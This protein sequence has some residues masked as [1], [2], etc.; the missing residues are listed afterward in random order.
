MQ[1]QHLRLLWTRLPGREGDH[2]F[3]SD[4]QHHFVQAVL[5]ATRWVGLKLPKTFLWAPLSQK[6]HRME[7]T[8]EPTEEQKQR[9]RSR[10]K[11][12][13]RHLSPA[14]YSTDTASRLL[15]HLHL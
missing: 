9:N 2:T 1:G 14:F 15:Y 6:R 5:T 4:P 12:G 13:D 7:G 8:E 10:S 3:L 11:K